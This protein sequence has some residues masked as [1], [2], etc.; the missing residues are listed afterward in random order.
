MLFVNDS[1]GKIVKGDI[2]LEQCM[3]SDEKIDI[4]ERETIKRFLARRPAFPARQYCH[5]N[6][7]GFRERRN[8]CKVMSRENFSWRYERSLPSGFDHGGGGGQGNDSLAG[9]DIALQEAQHPLRAGE[10]RGDVVDRFLLGMR[11]RVGQCL[12]DAGA[13]TPFTGTAAAR[14]TAHVRAHQ[15]QR[16]LSGKQ[17]VVGKSRPSPTFRLDVMRLCWPMQ[18]AEG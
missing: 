6:V 11:E 18:L 3:R 10:V 15:C 2:L 16:Q 5:T 17:F 13:E 9:P 8:G 1:E 14:L 7:S 12:Q 4:P